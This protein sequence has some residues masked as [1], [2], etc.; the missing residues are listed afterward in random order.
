MASYGVPQLGWLNPSPFPS[1]M[2]VSIDVDGLSSQIRGLYY[3]QNLFAS[4]PGLEVCSSI[5][6]DEL[7]HYDM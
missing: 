2:D 6:L 3:E 7:S 4:P 1:H 5:F